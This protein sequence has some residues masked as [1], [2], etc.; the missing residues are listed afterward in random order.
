MIIVKPQTQ[1]SIIALIFFI[2]PI[3]DKFMAHVFFGIHLKRGMYY[4]IYI[5]YIGSIYYYIF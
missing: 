5:L 3:T 4:I 1:S 2:A